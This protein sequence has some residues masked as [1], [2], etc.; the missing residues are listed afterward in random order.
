MKHKLEVFGIFK[1]FKALI[2]NSFKKNIKSIRPDKGGDYI[3]REFHHYCELEGIQMEHPVPY[4][5]Q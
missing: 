2:E 3:K 4:T 1:F 5:P